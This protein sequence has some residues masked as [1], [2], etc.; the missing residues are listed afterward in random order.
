MGQTVRLR[1]DGMGCEGCVAT[2]DAALRKVPGVRRVTV[3]RAAGTAEVEVESPV[4]TAS[5][6]AAVERAGYDAM[7]S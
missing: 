1:I 5:L 4:D 3:D 6:V 7:I 2:V